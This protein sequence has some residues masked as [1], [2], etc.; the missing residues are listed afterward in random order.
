[1][2]ALDMLTRAGSTQLDPSVRSASVF[3]PIATP[4]SHRLA[5][6]FDQLQLQPG[7]KMDCSQLQKGLQK[8]GYK[9]Q[10][11]E[12]GE[13][14][15][16]VDVEQRG[17]ISREELAAGLIDWKAFQDTYKDRWLEAARRAF[18]ELDAGGTG[19]LGSKEIAAAFGSHLQAYEV[20]AAVHQ[21]LLEAAEGRPGGP[22]GEGSFDH[23]SAANGGRA[24][25]GQAAGGGGGGE[26]AAAG[27]S[28]ISFD[29]FLCLLR[30]PSS[31]VDELDLDKFDARLSNHTSRQVSMWADDLKPVK[32][33]QGGGCCA[34]S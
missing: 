15:S 4:Y 23:S 24:A 7:Q 5:Q 3:L 10:E 8:I 17:E 18:A 2:R 1:M 22:A 31:G 16:V 14:F 30:Y 11:A 9:L 34:I 6:L 12:V 19:Q 28:R 20:D 27:D 21:A 32:A 33:Q 13:L 29:N 26:A 25:G